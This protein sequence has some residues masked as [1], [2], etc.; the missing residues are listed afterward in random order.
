MAFALL[1][2]TA[3]ATIIATSGQMTLIAP[4]PSV[5]IDALESD[6]TMYAFDEQQGVTLAQP[7]NVDITTP[8]T[9]DDT[10]DLTPGTIPAGTVVNSHFVNADHVGTQAPP[11]VLDGTITTDTDII[12]IEV[13]QHGLNI[14]DFLGA[15][16][17]AYPTGDFGRGLNLD[18]QDDF[19][20]EQIDR[21]TVEIHSQVRIHTDQVRI[22]TQGQRSR[23]FGYTMGFWGNQNGQ[24]LLAANDAFS[25]AKAVEIGISGLCYVK[26]DS[27]AKSKQILPSTKDGIGL[28]GCSGLL[29]SGISTGSFNTLLS[30]T[31]ALSYNILYKANYAGQTLGVM[32]CTPVG[33]LSSGSTVEQARTYAN[34][35]IGNAKKNAGDVITQSQIGDMNQLLG[36]LN[37]EA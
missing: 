14:S 10:T 1:A 21:R 6:T 33:P 9:Y 24:A 3:S 16:G 23:T 27:A 17:T 36:C 7:L 8:G 2:A 20:I 28:T 19:V 30:Q 29:D 5:E 31:L 12:G 25:P 13:L 22:I 26:V 32:G 11:V 4:P 37:A 18:D 35:L 15:P 34:Y